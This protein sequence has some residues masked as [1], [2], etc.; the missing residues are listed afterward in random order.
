MRFPFRA[1]GAN[2]RPIPEQ[3]TPAALVNEKESGVATERPPSSHEESDSDSIDKDAQR[4]VQEVEAMTKVWSGRDLYIAYALIWIIYFFDALQQGTTSLLTPYVTSTFD[5]HGLTPTVNVASSIIGGV[6]KLT[7]AKILD[8]WGRPQGYLF[9]LFFMVFGLLLMAVCQNVETYAAAQV[10]YWVG[11]NGF[12]YCITIFIADTSALKNR[13][14]MLAYTS[15]P[16]IITV[17]LTGRL[18]D[19]IYYG[20]GFRWGF[21]I[22]AIIT[23][24]ITLPLWWLFTYNQNKAKK[25]GVLVREK[26]GR[27]TFQSIKHYFFEFDVICLI[28]VTAGF[29]LFLLPFSIESYQKYGWKDPLTISFIVVGAVLLALAV[30]WEKYWAPVKFLPWE[31]LKDRTVLG[32]CILAAVLFIEYYI[33]TA[34]FSSFLQV[35]L[36]LDLT[37]TGYIS[38]IYTLGSCFFSIP[39]GL[40]IRWTG[41]FKWITLLFGVPA[42]ILAIG[43][44]I[45]LR[46]PGASI[47]GIIVVEILYAFA[48]GACVICEQVAVMAAAAHQH[49]TVVLA[50]EGMFSSVGGAIGST[51][52]GAIWAS[53]FPVKLKEYLP[54]S[55]QANFT[56]IYGELEVQLSYPVGSPTHDAIARAYGDSLKLMFI[57]ATAITVLGLVG[58][59]M[60]RDI[61][62]KNIKQVKGRVI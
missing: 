24:F 3:E 14:L 57:A 58:T 15:S 54:A 50:I 42:T 60:W 27:T 21:G 44:L 19:A 62:V 26:S 43:L 9:T 36:R 59:A 8:V 23:P 45:H 29:S 33:W 38:N 1:L 20:P 61:K 40:F 35:V 25:L 37:T 53:V 39:V 12:S 28:L 18:A 22:F 30:L 11:Y 31:L 17:W 48:G 2:E 32:A 41:R 6:S 5:S 49:V 51:V 52:A 47:A 34:Y 16:Y 7:L 46:Q 56:E 4:G 55:A 13:G 10:F